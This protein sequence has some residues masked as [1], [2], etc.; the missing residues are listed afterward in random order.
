MALIMTLIFMVVLTMMGLGGMENAW[1]NQKMNDHYQSMSVAFE[2]A[3]AGVHA[4]E[5]QING[6]TV[7]LSSSKAKINYTYVED[8]IDGCH[9]SVFSIHSFSSY[10]EANV[11]IIA[12]YLKVNRTILDG[13]PEST[14]RQLWWRQ[15]D[16]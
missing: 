12:S 7:N 14:S 16:A 2:G 6:Q 3:E 1:L 10:Q 13:C 15:I 4:A 11:K 8:Y 9:Q 5:A